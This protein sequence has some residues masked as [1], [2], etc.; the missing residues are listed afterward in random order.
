MGKLLEADD[1]LLQQ[2]LRYSELADCL[3]TGEVT[4]LGNVRNQWC[5]ALL[6]S[7]IQMVSKLMDVAHL[8]H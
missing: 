1:L 5:S 2:L 8:G 3:E 6:I 4:V 7:K